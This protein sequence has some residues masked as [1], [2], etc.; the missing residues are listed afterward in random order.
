MWHVVYRFDSAEHL[1]EWEGSEERAGLLASGA[2]FMETVAV[3]QLDGLDAWF[4]PRP[5]RVRRRG[6]RR[7]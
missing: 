3:R 5:G 2:A 1:E 7:S 4:A 6:G